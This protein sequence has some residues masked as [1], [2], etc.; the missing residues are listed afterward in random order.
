VPG[1]EADGTDRPHSHVEC[2]SFSPDGM[3]VVSLG[4][5][6]T[7]RL[8]DVLTGSMI[9]VFPPESWIDWDWNQDDRYPIGRMLAASYGAMNL[10]VLRYILSQEPL[11]RHP[12]SSRRPPIKCFLRCITGF[13]LTPTRTKG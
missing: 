9:C 4:D 3:R 6:E 12:L 1:D 2:C 11:V 10:C 7:L 8:W 13:G 5:D